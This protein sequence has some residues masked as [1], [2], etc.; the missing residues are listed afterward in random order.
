[1]TKKCNIDDLP[2]A[3]MARISKVKV[4]PPISLYG[5]YPS[6]VPARGTDRVLA[7]AHLCFDEGA[8]AIALV[9][10]PNMLDGS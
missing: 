8:K 7:F 5:R 6:T 1:M 4:A 9:A 2:I 3:W 10:E